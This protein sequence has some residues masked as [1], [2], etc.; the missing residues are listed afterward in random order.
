MNEHAAQALET[1]ERSRST[2]A[3]A[4]QDLDELQALQHTAAK[5]KALSTS[6]QL[7]LC[8]PSCA[9]TSGD[10]EAERLLAEGRMLAGPA[11]FDDLCCMLEARHAGRG[12]SD[13]QQLWLLPMTSLTAR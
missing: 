10:D 1:A 7:P 13:V 5:G 3:A 9:L 8:E 4:Q 12:T 6:S 11:C 2:A